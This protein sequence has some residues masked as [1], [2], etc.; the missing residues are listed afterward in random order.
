MS[1]HA[2]PGRLRRLL[3]VT[4]L[5][6]VAAT[7]PARASGQ[8]VAERRDS[9]DVG[10]CTLHYRVAG[11]GFLTALVLSGGPGSSADYLLPVQ[12]RLA[13]TTRAVLLDQRGTGSSTLRRMDSTTLKVRRAVDDIEAVRVRLGA[14]R[15]VLVGHSW[16][17]ALAMAYA[18]VHPEHVSA[19][20]LVGSAALDGGP[21]FARA[22][23]EHLAE[24]L[25]LA[26]RDSIRR[27]A[28]LETDPSRHQQALAQLARLDRKAYLSDPRNDAAVERSKATTTMNATVL[29]VMLADLA[30]TGHALDSELTSA[31]RASAP[32]MRVLVLFGDAD[33]IGESSAPEIRAAIPTAEVRVIPHSGHYP[34]IEAP[35][36]FYDAVNAFLATLRR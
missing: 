13:R 2:Q 9:I 21:G 3:L 24:R 15:V 26:D 30:R 23:G 12:A 14:S 34:W 11:R 16:G 28:A 22:V 10:D 8:T 5:A 27:W 19:L 33:V 4:S 1:I 17:G 36:A 29:R 20:V 25:T 32:P 7:S 6:C 18:A 31:A 35:E